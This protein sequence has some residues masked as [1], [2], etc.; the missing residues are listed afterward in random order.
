MP[1][2]ACSRHLA[3]AARGASSCGRAIAA[4]THES[5]G[6]ASLEELQH[7]GRVGDQRDQPGHRPLR[8]GHRG[9]PAAGCPSPRRARRGSARRPG[10]RR[11]V[12]RACPPSR[13][14]SSSSASST[15]GVGA[16]GRE[17]GDAR[18]RPPSA[19]RTPRASGRAAPPAGRLGRRLRVGDERAAAAAAGRLQVAALAERD[20]APGAASSARSR[21]CA[22]LAL[23]RQPRA[24]RQQPELDRRAEPLDRLLERGLRAD[25]REHGIERRGRVE[26]RRS[27]RSSRDRSQPLEAPD[28]L[29]VGDRRV[30][31]RELDVGG[32]E[33]VRRRPPRRTPRA[34]PRSRRTARAPRAASSAAA[35]C[36]SPGTRC[37]RTAGSSSSPCSTPCSPAAI[38]ALSAR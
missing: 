4:A 11:V 23:G 13:S 37:P 17:H 15:A 19:G 29:P 6:A 8:L 24:G 34:P 3:R 33:V 20:A 12:A 10:G 14:T 30:E 25:R 5:A 38:S 21:A 27:S 7:L 22:Q 32:V 36:R 35:A 16:L 2:A 26:L 1:L 31:R 9:R 18:P 28:A